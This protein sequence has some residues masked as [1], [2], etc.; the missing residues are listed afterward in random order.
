MR[1]RPNLDNKTLRRLLIGWICA[2]AV[3]APISAK[4]APKSHQET[5]LFGGATRTYFVFTP[6]G[7]SAP[8]PVLVLLHGSGHNGASLIGPWRGLAQKEGIILVA[9]DSI[10][11]AEWN[12]RKDSPDF[13]H[14]VLDEIASKYP[15][16]AQRLYLFGHSAGAMYALYLSVAE[17]G[18]F[19]ATAVHAGALLEGDFTIIDSA[20][21]K[22]PLAIWV[23]SNDDFFPLAQVRATRD[24]F[25]ARGFA[26]ELHEMP[27]HDHDYYAVS[28]KVNGPAWQFLKAKTLGQEPE[29]RTLA[30][31]V[32]PVA[33][34]SSSKPG[35]FALEPTVLAF[36]RMIWESAKPYL[37]DS[38]PQLTA[39][40]AE[41]RG[42]D[43]AQ[44][45]QGL[46]QLLKKIGDKTLDLMGKM[47]D[48]ISHEQ[49]TVR[50]EP[51]G[52]TT[53]EQY[54]YLVLRHD[55][56]SKGVV[57]LDEY[58]TQNG[59]TG[60]SPISQGGANK[61]VLFHPGNLIESRFRLL[62]A[63]RI[64]G[65]A[66]IVVAFAQ[67]PGK[68]R[69]PG[70]VHFKGTSIPVL[71]QGIVWI[72]AS[73]FRIVRLRSDLLSPRPDIG[74]QALTT[75]VLFSEVHIGGPEFADSLWLPQ[76]VHVTSEYEGRIVNQ[77]HRY[78]GF[79]LYRAKSRLVM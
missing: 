57:T 5:L 10:D 79:R 24:A 18:Y 40:L 38:L 17:S 77:V 67:I 2:L 1:A 36:D 23:G 30:Q 13:L 55:D 48:V 26:V 27:H 76:E 41:L 3:A 16:D 62:G 47:P 66:T 31:L 75:E 43:P 70:Q 78:S 46:P 44:D 58:R 25:D 45:Q 49:V 35:N 61:W 54:D 12:C 11:S 7:L 8:A 39:S 19:A 20:T 14:K 72:D 37:D 64:D 9:P 68:V 63:Q 28:D 6:G 22:I 59:K 69:F 53:H 73:D 56:A 42:L 33:N 4:T 29:F 60:A 65:H 21:R 71:Y 32:N 51:R 15:V 74:L 52:P 34:A 50:A